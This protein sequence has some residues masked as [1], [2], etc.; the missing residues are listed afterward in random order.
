VREIAGEDG[1]SKAIDSVAGQL[2]AD[3]FHSLAPGGEMIVYGALSSHRQTEADRL[4]LPLDARSVI[5]GTKTV[6][7]FWLYRW[8]TITRQQQIGAALAQTLQPLRRRDDPDPRRTADT[9]AALRR[10]RAAGRDTGPRRQ[11]AARACRRLTSP[12]IS[13]PSRPRRSA[14][15]QA[16][17]APAFCANGSIYTEAA[18]ATASDESQVP[19]SP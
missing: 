19:L 12:H 9:P 18:R 13:P 16:A 4:T 8:F 10:R 15:Q 2:G 11:A 1:V 3:V 14:Y 7:G 6:R 5:Y 17:S